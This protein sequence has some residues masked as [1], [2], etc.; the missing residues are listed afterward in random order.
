VLLKTVDG[1]A[2]TTSLGALKLI[3][4]RGFQVAA[5]DAAGNVGAKT[6]VLK[7]VPKLATLKMTAAMKALKARGFKL[8][9]ISYKVSRTVPKGKVIKGTLANLQPAGAKIGL[10]VS[11]GKPK[12]RRAS[13]TP[14]PPTSPGTTPPP[15][16]FV[17]PT[18]PVA[19]V[20]V[21]TPSDSG[22]PAPETTPTTEST[23]GVEIPSL[24]RPATSK[25]GIRE[26]RQELGFGLLVA[27]FSVAIG[28]GLRARRGGGT[29]GGDQAGE[30]LF[31]DARLLRSIGRAF[32]RIFGRG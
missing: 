23:D 29:S 21:P 11:K 9:R 4:K 7:V 12:A 8:G 18:G 5:V 27:A 26:L 28:S 16:S 15:S 2:R 22:S 1:S 10:V 3:D 32:R 19:Y 30:E 17:P 20:P 6:K 13:V 31:W 24:N 25:A 14:V